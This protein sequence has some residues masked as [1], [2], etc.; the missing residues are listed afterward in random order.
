[1]ELAVV[2][3]KSAVVG[4]ADDI[5]IAAPEQYVSIFIGL[6]GLDGLRCNNVIS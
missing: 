4:G 5:R 2:D 6:S 3:S 1:M